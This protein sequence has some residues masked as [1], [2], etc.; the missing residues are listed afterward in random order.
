VA[1]WVAEGELPEL[2]LDPQ[3]S[4]D[5][6]MTFVRSAVGDVHAEDAAWTASDPERMPVAVEGHS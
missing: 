6:L 3:P 5:E 4:D 2:A 1:S